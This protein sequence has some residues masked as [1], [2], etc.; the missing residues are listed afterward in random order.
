MFSFV[1]CRQWYAILL[2]VHFFI[3]FSSEFIEFVFQDFYAF[4]NFFICFVFTT[5]IFVLFATV[6]IFFDSVHGYVLNFISVLWQ[7]DEFFASVF[8]FIM[9]VKAFYSLEK[10][11]VMCFRSVVFSKLFMIVIF[12]SFFRL[13][14]IFLTTNLCIRCL[15]IDFRSISWVIFLSIFSLV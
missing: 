7:F 14:L 8:L 5:V 4:L 2:R 12:I 9:L 6:L 10:T 15:A 11:K 3:Y 1:T 13:K